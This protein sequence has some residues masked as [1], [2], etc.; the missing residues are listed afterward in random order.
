MTRA[1]FENLKE[2]D[3]LTSETRDAVIL[4][5]KH[6]NGWYVK[7]CEYSEDIQDYVPTGSDYILTASE[8]KRDF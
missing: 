2:G 7:D 8:I 3:L 5:Q 4:V 1:D 6:F